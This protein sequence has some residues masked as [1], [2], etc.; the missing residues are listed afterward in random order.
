MAMNPALLAALAR[1]RHMEA[2]RRGNR[3]PRSSPR[4]R[5]RRTGRVAKPGSGRIVARIQEPGV[6]LLCKRQ[7]RQERLKLV[8]LPAERDPADDFPGDAAVRAVFHP[9]TA[10]VRGGKLPT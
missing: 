5:L 7:G 6:L 10:A 4:W 3:T 8:V 1:E 2:I 9:H